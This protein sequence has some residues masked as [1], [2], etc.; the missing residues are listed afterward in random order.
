VSTAKVI[1]MEWNDLGEGEREREQ[2]I[3]GRRRTL[4]FVR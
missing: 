1:S 4:L 2:N 3:G